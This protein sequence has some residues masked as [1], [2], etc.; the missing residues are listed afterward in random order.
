MWCTPGI[1]TW[2]SFISALQN[3]MENYAKKLSFRIFA[4]DTNVFY[5][6]KSIDHVENVMNE[7]LAKYFIIVRLINYQ[8]ILKRPILW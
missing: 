3:D 5:S 4:D 1:H 7:E 6:G 8:S 2:A